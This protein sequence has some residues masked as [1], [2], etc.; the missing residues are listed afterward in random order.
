LQQYFLRNWHFP[1]T[2]QSP[3]TELLMASERPGPYLI[4]SDT[5]PG[6][7]QL[8]A[9]AAD[10]LSVIGTIMGD[11]AHEDMAS[12]RAGL[13]DQLGDLRAAID[14]VI[15]KN[16]LDWNAVNSRRDRKRSLYERQ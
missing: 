14:Y 16:A 12:L 11:D 10:V 9:D 7:S 3:R 13:Q 2:S 5:W 4:G 1:G 15:G 8:T 6:L